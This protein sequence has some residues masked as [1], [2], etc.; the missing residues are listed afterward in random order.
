MTT[1]QL[2]AAGV[3]VG[4][5]AL[6]SGSVAFATQSGDGYQCLLSHAHFDSHR[7][8]TTCTGHTP[9][10]VAPLE[11]AKCDPAMMRDAAMRAQCKAMGEQHGAASQPAASG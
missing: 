9:E 11:A 7:I 3:A 2:A 8:V 6:L 4:L 5:F 1:N 10:A